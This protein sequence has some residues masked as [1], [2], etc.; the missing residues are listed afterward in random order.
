MVVVFDSRAGERMATMREALLL[1]GYPCA[2]ADVRMMKRL[3]PMR[4]IVTFTDQINEVRRIPYDHIPVVAY[5]SGFIN[6]ALNATK[7]ETPLELFQKINELMREIYGLG[8]HNSFLQDGAFFCPGVYLSFS[9]LIV[10]GSRIHLTDTELMIM[11][12]LILSG[13]G[14][15]SAEQIAAFCCPPDQ[16]SGNIRVHILNINRKASRSLPEP[17]VE[18]KYGS[19]YRF[20]YFPTQTASRR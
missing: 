8:E 20:G 5:G 10:Y 18:S 12:Y 11:K 2:F 17:L 3:T 7:A 13:N 14:F 4:L 15:R 9:Q 6:R 19:G 1:K 16:G